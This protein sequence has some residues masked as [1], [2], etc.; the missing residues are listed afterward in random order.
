M[1]VPPPITQAGESQRGEDCGTSWPQGCWCNRCTPELQ[2][3]TAQERPHQAE[4]TV[5]L[6]K[7]ASESPARG[8]TDSQNSVWAI[9]LAVMVSSKN[10]E[11]SDQGSPQKFG[12]F[13]KVNLSHYET[14][15]FCGISAIAKKQ[16]MTAPAKT[17]SKIPCQAFKDLS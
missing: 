10:P 8:F 15:L 9:N 4:V 1:K 6:A 11:G 13:V 14:H 12:C 16:K 5:Y 7:V 17:T 3:S 2:V